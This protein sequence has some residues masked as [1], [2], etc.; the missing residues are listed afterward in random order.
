[1]DEL[2]TQIK[3]AEAHGKVKPEHVFSILLSL[4]EKIEALSGP[5]AV[6]VPEVAAPTSTPEPEIEPVVETTPEP[7]PEADEEE[8]EAEP[9]EEEDEE[10]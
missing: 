5:V 4:V 9:E 1:M 7:E 10:V 6:A 2:R 8:E 3:Q